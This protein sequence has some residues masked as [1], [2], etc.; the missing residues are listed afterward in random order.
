MIKNLR[1]KFNLNA[2]DSAEFNGRSGGIWIRGDIC[3]EATGY[4]GYSNDTLDADNVLNKYLSK[5]GFFAESYD[6]ETIMIYNI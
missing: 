4:Y 2:V 1:S 3:C 5:H 6:S